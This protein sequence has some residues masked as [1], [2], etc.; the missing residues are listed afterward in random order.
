MIED[1]ITNLPAESTTATIQEKILKDPLGRVKIGK[2]KAGHQLSDYS[3]K[4]T[5][6]LSDRDLGRDGEIPQRNSLKPYSKGRASIV[7]TKEADEG[8]W[9]CR[10][11]LPSGSRHLCLQPSAFKGNKFKGFPFKADSSYDI[12]VDSSVNTNM[13]CTH[14]SSGIQ[15]RIRL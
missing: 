2:I 4:L 6:I 13:I 1:E 14:L 9:M 5:S 11:L 8:I 7:W 15:G 3:A 10:L 12:E